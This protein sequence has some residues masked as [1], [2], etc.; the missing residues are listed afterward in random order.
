MKILFFASL[1]ERLNCE[2]LNLDIQNTPVSVEDVL[3]TL[4][5]R[6]DVWEEALT[7]N[8]LLVAV[9][10]EMRSFDTVLSNDDELA[11]FP[12]VTGG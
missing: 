10:Q 12:P 6:G 11:F 1:K 5:A 7:A 8:K 3:N 2:A 9:N 4:K